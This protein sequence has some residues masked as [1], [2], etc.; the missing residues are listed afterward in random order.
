MAK[1]AERLD[2]PDALTEMVKAALWDQLHES[3][4]PET[5]ERLALIL[6]DQL[7]NTALVWTIASGCGS[8]DLA[9]EHPDVNF[10]VL[11]RVLKLGFQSSPRHRP[12]WRKFGRA[13]AKLRLLRGDFAGMNAA[14][15]VIGMKAI[16]EGQRHSLRAPPKDWGAGLP[17][18]WTECDER[19]RSGTCTLEMQF[20]ANGQGLAG[21]H[22]LVRKGNP[23]PHLWSSGWPVTTLTTNPVPYSTRSGFHVS[24]FGFES[25]RDR[26]LS[27]YAVTDASGEIRFTGLPATDVIL[28]V[29][30][31]TA[32]FTGPGRRYT[33][34]LEG[35]E[36]RAA[37]VVLLEAGRTFRY[38]KLI[39]EPLDED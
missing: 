19:L 12:Y 22:V 5:A 10:D 21:V 28:E 23:F 24:G 20:E 2:E 1:W 35:H 33:L 34:R 15:G 6:Q 31:P 3:P 11:E 38:P 29:V 17:L 30:I 4:N 25:D 37:P 9:P 16:E 32:N 13:L 14:L 26:H 27:R 39:L 18:R 7:A 8:N 36:G